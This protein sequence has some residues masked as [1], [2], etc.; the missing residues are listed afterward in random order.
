MDVADMVRLAEDEQI[1]VA[2]DFAVPGIETRAAI[3][4]L[5]EA[6]RLD[7]GAHGA[8]EHQDALARELAQRW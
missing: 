2:A 1:V 5:V 4:L 7:H 8:I 3:A 6:E